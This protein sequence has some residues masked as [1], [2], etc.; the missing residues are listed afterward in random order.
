[1]DW[2]ASLFFERPGTR[3]MPEPD[4]APSH[5]GKNPIVPKRQR[6]TLRPLPAATR[7][8][9]AWTLGKSPHFRG[10]FLRNRRYPAGPTALEKGPVLIDNAL[11]YKGLDRLHE[12]AIP[13]KRD[14]REP[15]PI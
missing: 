14:G 9:L 1:M 12:S 4:V 8:V 13:G 6:L 15:V 10:N 11:F 7:V 3:N 5:Q 2:A